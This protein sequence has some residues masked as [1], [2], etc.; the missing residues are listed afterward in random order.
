MGAEGLSARG[1]RSKGEGPS[2]RPHWSN[3]RI[4]GTA[5]ND[6]QFSTVLERGKFSCEVVVLASS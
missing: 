5:G 1:E 4:E 3:K 6:A 2:E